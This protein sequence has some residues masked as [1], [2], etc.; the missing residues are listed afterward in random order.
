M[1]RRTNQRRKR[2]PSP[3]QKQIRF[4]TGLTLFIII[5]LT[6]LIFWFANRGVAAH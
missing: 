3:H 1:S 2:N 6:I 4:L 5:L